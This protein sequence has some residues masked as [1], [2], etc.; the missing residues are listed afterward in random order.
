MRQRQHTPSSEQLMHSW[1]LSLN[2]RRSKTNA[3]EPSLL[4][5][6]YMDELCARVRGLVQNVAPRSVPLWLHQGLAVMFEP[7]G[8]EC[9]RRELAKAPGRLPMT[10]LTGGFEPLSAP[11][12]RL[13]YAQSAAL[14]GTLFEMRGPLAVGALLQDLARGDT[15]AAAFERRFFTPYASFLAGLE[16]AAAH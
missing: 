15:F 14:V 16:P 12:A 10:R 1:V 4:D 5:Y 6:H 11:E 7:D 8:A 2:R 13:A 9:T 3:D